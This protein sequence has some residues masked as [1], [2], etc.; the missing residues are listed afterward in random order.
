MKSD[1]IVDYDLMRLRNIVAEIDDYLNSI[2]I[3]ASGPSTNKRYIT[4]KINCIAQDV[5]CIQSMADT[6]ENE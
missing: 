2:R 1:W 3:E 5:R 4:E 6:S